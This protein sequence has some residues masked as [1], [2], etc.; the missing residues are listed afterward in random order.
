MTEEYLVRVAP[1]EGGY[2]LRVARVLGVTQCTELA[3]AE[4]MVRSWL[5][6]DGEPDAATATIRL[7]RDVSSADTA[8]AHEEGSVRRDANTALTFADLDEMDG[9]WDR[10]RWL[11][12]SDDEGDGRADTDGPYD[13][14][15]WERL[16]APWI[17]L[18]MMLS[19]I[20]PIGILEYAS[21]P[22]PVRLAGR[23]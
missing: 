17:L 1:W 9:G 4:A 19:S 23:R 5:Q 11:A 7:V 20:M 10:G 6:L 16:A 18:S 12:P 13:P 8:E 3:D 22:V 2:E 21:Q 15:S 14:G